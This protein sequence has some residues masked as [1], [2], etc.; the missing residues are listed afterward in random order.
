MS[1]ARV[2]WQGEPDRV[3]TVVALAKAPNALV[4]WK[5]A[6]NLVTE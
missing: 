6:G 5:L 3:R 4:G 1:A 2:E